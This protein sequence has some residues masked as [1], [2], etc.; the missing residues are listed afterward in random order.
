MEDF[1]KYDPLTNG[2]KGLVF[3]GDK[4]VTYRRDKDAPRHPDEIDIPG[5]GPE[6]GETPFE[7]LRRESY[8]EFGL[9]IKKAHIV[10]YRKYPSTMT[11]GK[12]DYFAVCKLPENAAQKIRF[13]NEGVSYSLMEIRQFIKHKDG[14]P[15]FQKRAT[16]YLRSEK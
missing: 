14:W 9:D 13:G 16:D 5:G 7:T 15:I 6:P 3:I 8:E 10:Y 1:F 4:I 11:A 2:T 12:Y